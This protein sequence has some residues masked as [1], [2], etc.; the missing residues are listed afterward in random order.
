MFTFNFFFR[1]AFIT[2]TFLYNEKYKKKSRLVSK[3]YLQYSK[4]SDKEKGLDG[5]HEIALCNRPLTRPLLMEWYAPAVQIIVTG[6]GFIR[7]S[8][9][10]VILEGLGKLHQKIFLFL[11]EKR[12][13]LINF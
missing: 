10:Q 2:L 12:S 7:K 6:G 3:S 9:F 4:H 1:I 13:I 8:K 11:Y 5:W